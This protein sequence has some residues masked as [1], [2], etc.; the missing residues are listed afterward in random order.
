MNEKAAVSPND[1]HTIFQFN[2]TFPSYDYSRPLD[3]MNQYHHHGVYH[4]DAHA[5]A[6][7]CAFRHIPIIEV[8]KMNLML[9]I[10]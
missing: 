7:I 10:P 4:A 5:R 6:Q 2:I 9:T 3:P 8:R 1:Q